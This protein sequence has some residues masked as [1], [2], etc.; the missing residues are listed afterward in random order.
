MGSGNVQEHEGK[1]LAESLSRRLAAY[2]LAATATAGL[3][4]TAAAAPAEASIISHTTSLSLSC[5]MSGGRSGTHLSLGITKSVQLSFVDFC[6]SFRSGASLGVGITQPFGPGKFIVSPASH[7]G[8]FLVSMPARLGKGSPIKASLAASFLGTLAARGAHGSTIFHGNWAP[9]S[10]IFPAP[11]ARGYLGFEFGPK[12]GEHVG[13]VAM[14]VVASGVD[15]AAHIT[16]Y[17]YDTVPR[18]TVKAGQTSPVPEPPT[19][20]LLALGAA[21]LFAL[22]KRKRSA[23]RHNESAG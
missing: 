3:G 11:P 10:P 8:H 14:T 21:G 2:A 19:L 7:G 22:R 20:S 17:A 5:P 12:S 9:S 16:G 6:T 4:L 18:Q 1:Q 23:A 15:F 13:W